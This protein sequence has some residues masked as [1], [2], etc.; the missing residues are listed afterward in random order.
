MNTSLVGNIVSTARRARAAEI[1]AGI[2]WYPFA[3]RSALAMSGR[4]LHIGAGVIAALSPLTPWDR[5]V[6]L[7][8]R[9]FEQGAASGTLFVNVAKANAILAGTDPLEVLGGDKVR[10]FYS[11][12]VNPMGDDVTIDRHAFDI[13][14]GQFT[15]DKERKPL[16]NKG[17]YETFAQAYRDAGTV[18]GDLTGAQVQAITWVAWRRMKGLK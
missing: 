2:N 1:D 5:N 4:K 7:A 16:K 6:M 12:I 8:N 15:S 3:Q 9:A 10:S 17:V 11:N 14:M 13:A 18:L